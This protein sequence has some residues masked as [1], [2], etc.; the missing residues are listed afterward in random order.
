MVE[1]MNDYYESGRIGRAL[2][3]QSD[4]TGAAPISGLGNSQQRVDSCQT[5]LWTA[6]TALALADKAAENPVVWR[7]YRKLTRLIAAGAGSG[8]RLAQ[9]NRY[10]ELA[11]LFRG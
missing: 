6:E 5:G 9:S 8:G 7:E 4:C 10:Q 1:K 3:G 2:A 11:K